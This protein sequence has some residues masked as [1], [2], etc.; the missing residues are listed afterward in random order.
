MIS[1]ADDGIDGDA[2][3]FLRDQEERIN[4]LVFD[5]VARFGGS[6]S[7]EHGIGLEKR[8]WL[9]IT[10]SAEEVALMRTI[11]AALDPKNLLNP[12]KVLA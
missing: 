11:K 4:T 12:G 6:I 5:A 3:A 10:R 8:D 2:K 1:E 9:H 7:A